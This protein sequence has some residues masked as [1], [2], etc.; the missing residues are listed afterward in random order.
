M[1]VVPSLKMSGLPQQK[2]HATSVAIILPICICSVSL[3]LYA[4]YVTIADA[5]P[6]LLWGAIGSVIGARL[7]PKLNEVLLKRIFGALMLWAGIRMLL[8]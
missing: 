7:L 8:R 5:L 3:Y 1:L 2:A 6:Y 4:G